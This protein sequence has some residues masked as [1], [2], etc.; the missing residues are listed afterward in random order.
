[1]KFFERK[2]IYRFQI[3]K[4]VEGKNIMTRNLSSSVLEKCNGYETIRH[5]L[6]CQEK[7]EFFPIGIVYEPIYDERVPVLCF[8]TDRMFLAYRS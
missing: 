8:F 6:A 1:M 4:E 2:E 5:E 7:R 3:K